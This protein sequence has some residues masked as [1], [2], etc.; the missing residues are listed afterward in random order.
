MVA[1]FVLLFPIEPFAASSTTSS[2]RRTTSS[3]GR[4]LIGV[5]LLVA[6]LAGGWEVSAA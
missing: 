3:T 4:S 6:V 2:S 1:A 5:A